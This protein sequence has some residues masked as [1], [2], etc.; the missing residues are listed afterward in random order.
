[1][2]VAGTANACRATLWAK[3]YL[4]VPTAFLKTNHV[5]INMDIMPE[6][7]TQVT[8]SVVL[9]MFSKIVIQENN[10]SQ[11]IQFAVTTTA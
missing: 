7:T 11:Q 6:Q 2:K 5:K 4:E 9:G 10:V 1:M 8:V 3:V